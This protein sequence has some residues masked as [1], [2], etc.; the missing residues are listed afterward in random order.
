MLKELADFFCESELPIFLY[1]ETRP[2][3]IKKST[4]ELL[5]ALKVD[6]VGMGIELASEEFRKSSLNRYPSQEKITEAFFLLKEAGIK[7]TSYNIIGL[8]NETEKMIWDTIRLNQTLDPDN[9]T[10]AFYSP[11]LGT[12]E[13]IKSKDINYFDEYEYHVDGQLRTVTKSTMIEKKQLNF[14][15]TYF[16]RLVRE[17]LDKV[18]SFKEIEGVDF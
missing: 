2:E 6:G 11:Y 9:I 15:K 1:I 13:Q 18:N 10:V 16:V 3:T 12:P 5:K 8:P 17:G 14:Y 4:I 7:R